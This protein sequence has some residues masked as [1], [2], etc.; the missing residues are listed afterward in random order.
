VYTFPEIQVGMIYG[1][2]AAFGDDSTRKHHKAARNAT[3][4]LARSYR[5]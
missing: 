1:D 5:G 4:A 2:G 3:L